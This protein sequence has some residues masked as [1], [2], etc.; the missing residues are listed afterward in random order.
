MEVTVWAVDA[1][2]LNV[3]GLSSEATLGIFC[4]KTGQSMTLIFPA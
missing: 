4:F 1:P 2:F 3:A